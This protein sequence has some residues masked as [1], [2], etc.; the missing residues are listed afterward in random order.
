MVHLEVTLVLLCTHTTRSSEV[1]RYYWWLRDVSVTSEY[2]YAYHFG[3]AHCNNA[4]YMHA[5]T[6]ILQEVKVELTGGFDPFVHRF[7]L[8]LFIML[9]VQIVTVRL[10]TVLYSYYI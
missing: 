4:S 2:V 9:D 10:I 7:I 1:T 3:N 6:F 5:V 8:P